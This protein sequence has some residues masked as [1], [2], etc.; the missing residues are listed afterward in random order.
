MKDRVFSGSD[1]SEAVALAAANLGLPLAQLRYV[2]LEAGSP[3]GRGLSPTPARIA[4]LLEDVREADSRRPPSAY[5]SDRG[6]R[7][8]G[9][10]GEAR[11]IEPRSGIRDTIRAIAEAGG[12]ELSAEVSDGPEVLKVELAGAD[13]GFFMEPDGSA[14]VLRATE[15]LLLRLYGAALMPRALRLSGEGFREQRDAALAAEARRLA[16]AV[17]GDGQPREMPSLNS[18]ERRVVHMTLAEVPGVTTASAGEGPTRRL[19]IA[20]AAGPGA[21]AKGDAAPE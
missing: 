20:P 3:G 9:P 21:G 5:P 4:V 19:T 2:V 6:P 14:E 8:G 1:V 11:E 13:R 17:L 15:H 12:L 10:R 7:A 16:E 18:Y